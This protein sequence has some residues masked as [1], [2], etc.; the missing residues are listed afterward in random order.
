MKNRKGKIYDSRRRCRHAVEAA[1]ETTVEA[2]ATT[3]AAVAAAVEIRT[4]VYLMRIATALA[5]PGLLFA[6]ACAP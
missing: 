5:N 4:G 3:A 2:A 6:A 1:V